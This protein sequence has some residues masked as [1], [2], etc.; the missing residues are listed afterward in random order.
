MIDWYYDD[1]NCYCCS[2]YY[3][4]WLIDA[5]A[6]GRGLRCQLVGVQ[7]ANVCNSI[8]FEVDLK[9]DLSVCLISSEW[10]VAIDRPSWYRP[11]AS[12]YSNNDTRID[13]TCN[14]ESIIIIVIIIAIIFSSKLKSNC[15]N[16]WIV[17]KKNFVRDGIRTRAALVASS[18]SNH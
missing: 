6:V 8:D 18:D 9:V 14:T 5:C 12:M 16:D 13:K 11:M 4:F 2:Y 1:M 17:K 7:L 3:E 15:K 10:T